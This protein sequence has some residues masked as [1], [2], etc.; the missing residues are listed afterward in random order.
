MDSRSEV[1]INKTHETVM[2]IFKKTDD[3]QF[4]KD[5]TDKELAIIQA[6]GM[7]LY[8]RSEEEFEGRQ[9]DHRVTINELYM[10]YLD[11]IGLYDESNY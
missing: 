11:E 9:R 8:V 1:F 6:F 2:D 4:L 7:A 3:C 5:L 10:N